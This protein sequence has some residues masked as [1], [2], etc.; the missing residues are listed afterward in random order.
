MDLH[1][2]IDF[3]QPN[4]YP[5]FETHSTSKQIWDW[6]WRRER[7]GVMALDLSPELLQSIKPGDVIGVDAS[8]GAVSLLLRPVVFSLY[9]A[10]RSFLCCHLSLSLSSSLPLSRF[11]FPLLPYHCWHQR[12]REKSDEEGWKTEEGWGLCF[13]EDDDETMIK[14]DEEVC[15][16]EWVMKK[17]WWRLIFWR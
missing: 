6:K 15:E 3:H 17:W 2:P 16:R 14:G 13:C 1:Q 11:L 4:R 9:L 12:A 7:E 8:G 5:I 10:P